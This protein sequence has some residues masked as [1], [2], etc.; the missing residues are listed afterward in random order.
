VSALSTATIASA[1]GNAR[2][3]GDGYRCRCPLSE[4]HNNGDAYPSFSI[5]E[6]RGTILVRCHSRHADEQPR[7]IEALKARDLWP[8][9]NRSKPRCA[10]TNCDWKP[11]LPVP[12]DAAVA[13]N[14]DFRFRNSDP[15]AVWKYLDADRRLLGYV[16][17]YNDR[18]KG[19][20]LTFCANDN[21]Q[22]SW[23][24]KGFP[25]PRPLFGLEHIAALPQATV[26]IVEGE[27][28]AYLLQKSL[29]SAGIV[30][31]VAVTWPGGAKT[32]GKTDWSPLRHRKVIIFPDH[33]RDGFDAAVYVG[34]KLD[35]FQN[36]T[37]QTVRI[38]KPDPDWPAAHDVAD[39]L[40]DSWDAHQVLE[41]LNTRS[42]L[43]DD[44]ETYSREYFGKISTVPGNDTPAVS[45][46]VG[47]LARLSPL[48]YDQN[49]RGEAKRLGVRV[50]TLDDEVAKAR[51]PIP[52]MGTASIDLPLIV[53][54]S[55]PVGSCILF[56]DIRNFVK[57][58]L[59]LS[60]EQLTAIVL[61]ILFA[62]AFE[63]AEISP[64]L[65]LL[66]PK[67]RCGKSTAERILG[68]L[69]PRPLTA[70]NISPSA[71]FRTI[72]T[73]KPTLILD[74]V[75]SF[76][77]GGKQ[78]S[79]RSEEIRGILNSGHTRDQAFVIRN[80]KQGDDWVPR[81]FSTWAPIVYAAIGR[82]PETWEDRSIKLMMKR[83]LKTEKVE[84]LTRRN[85][86]IVHRQAA[87][88]A[89]R[90]ARWAQDNGEALRIAEPAIPQ[91]L[92]DRAEDNWDLLLAIADLGGNEWGDRARA[93]AV[94][95]SG[96]R[97]QDADDSL[98]IKLLADIRRVLGKTCVQNIGSTELCSKL[99]AIE[100]SPWQSMRPNDKPLTTRRL[101]MMLKPF[102]VYPKGAGN[103]NEYEVPAL[104]SVFSR[105]LP[106]PAFQTSNAPQTIGGVCKSDDTQTSS[107]GALDS[108]DCHTERR[109]SGALAVRDQE[110]GPEE[111]RG[112][113]TERLAESD[114]EVF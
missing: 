113:E 81:Q 98:D 97:D 80:A 54:S 16:C 32:P 28:C 109:A 57:R 46:V 102:E 114:R 67:K 104:E 96:D 61:W 56:N 55:K 30:D 108:A 58:F 47:R 35:G 6:H 11:L 70:S 94:T 95:L 92:N 62:H 2:P 84:K 37:P 103:R 89:S 17:R 68:L 26:V 44:F 52:G 27:K 65:A 8:A 78:K 88:L 73:V 49:R 100:S 3:E 19:V 76:A 38:V 101:A 71:I 33:D 45:V 53:P 64:R 39:L 99:A 85:L 112:A 91:G 106:I 29:D 14:R 40:A 69:C 12:S 110:A 51:K 43:V 4:E 111:T 24:F 107:G 63:V 75:D 15:W 77:S 21:G 34:R 66:S 20:P 36:A 82:L 105:Y 50:E 93:A 9:R 23:R 87:E 90:C 41:F 60:P 10:R 22:R 59:V 72:E 1:L 25:E 31:Y 48:E 7:I 83:R 74:E 13:T 5:R 18:D 79:E 42:V 86:K